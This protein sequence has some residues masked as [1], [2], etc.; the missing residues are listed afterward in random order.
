MSGLCDQHELTRALDLALPTI[1]RLHFGQ[2]I[3]AGSLPLGDKM[4]RNPASLLYR[5]CHR[6]YKA[7]GRHLES[8]VPVKARDCQLVIKSNRRVEGRPN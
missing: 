7:E 5:G 2:N 1:N 3:D 8:Q 6:E 4:P